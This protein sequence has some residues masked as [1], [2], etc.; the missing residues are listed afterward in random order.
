MESI[1]RSRAGAHVYVLFLSVVATAAS[2]SF[3]N[4]D[5]ETISLI[6]HD[7]FCHRSFVQ[8]FVL[9]SKRTLESTTACESR[10]DERRSLRVSSRGCHGENSTRLGGN[11]REKKRDRVYRRVAQRHPT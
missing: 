9:A 10:A 7:L 8:P 2:A 11:S 6:D 3:P 1:N 5:R 4:G